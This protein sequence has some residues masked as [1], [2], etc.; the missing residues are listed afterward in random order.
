MKTF[1][2]FMAESTKG[3]IPS[4]IHFKYI[5]ED[6][7]ESY[8]T[9][10]LND[11]DNNEKLARVGR[12]TFTYIPKDSFSPK[13]R[14]AIHHYTIESRNI[15]KAL[16]REHKKKPKNIQNRV[17]NRIHFPDVQKVLGGGEHDTRVLHHI[18]AAIRNHPLPHDGTTYSGISFDPRKHLNKDGI[19]HSPSYL[20]TTH[21]IHVAHDYARDKMMKGD[22]GK[23]HMMHINLRKGDPAL[24]VS[25]LSQHGGEHEVIIK[26]GIN[27]KYIKTTIDNDSMFHPIHVHHFEI[28]R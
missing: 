1:K 16:L 21:D 6:L 5:G 3:V 4:P 13:Q 10:S 7:N 22:K 9:Y 19:L 11:P 23:V 12:D 17:Y 20:S 26:A 27:L 28:A 24:H 14:D 25:H 15:N 18:D 2:Q 8:S